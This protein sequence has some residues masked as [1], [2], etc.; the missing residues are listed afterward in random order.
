M[1]MGWFCLL[2]VSMDVMKRYLMVL[3]YVCTTAELDLFS[4]TIYRACSRNII[5][6]ISQ[7][8]QGPPFLRHHGASSD[9]ESRT[10]QLLGQEA[11]EICIASRHETAETVLPC[12][13]GIS[14]L[15]L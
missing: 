15:V 2:L 10:M 6:L 14:Y 1:R 5:R 4:G 11:R 12:R 9:H 8:G 3:L 13:Y 7:E